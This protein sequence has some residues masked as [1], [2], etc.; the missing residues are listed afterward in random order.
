MVLSK[1]KWAKLTNILARLRGISRDVG[2]SRHHALTSATAVFSPTP[3]IPG[4]ADP[5]VVVQS[6]PIP[7][8]CKGKAIV[9]DRVR[10]ELR[11]G[12]NL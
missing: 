6:S 11:R 8:P 1:E 12:A 10:R 2:T 9:S 3:S 4:V 7:F 5:L